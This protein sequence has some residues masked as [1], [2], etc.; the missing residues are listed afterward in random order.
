MW[1]CE[2]CH[3]LFQTGNQPQ[4]CAA[5]TVCSRCGLDGPETILMMMFQKRQHQLQSCHIMTAEIAQLQ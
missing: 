3:H 5:M 2:Q 4:S 1:T